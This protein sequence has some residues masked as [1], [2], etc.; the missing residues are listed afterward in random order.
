MKIIYGLTQ[1]KRKLPANAATMGVFDGVHLG[2]QAIL[3]EVVKRSKVLNL[4]SLCVTFWPS[5]KN[6]KLLYSLKHRLYLIEKIGF[7]I[8]VVINFTR[9][10][11]NLSPESFVRGI[12]V[13]KLNTSEII[14]GHGFKFAKHQ[15]G[16]TKLL[17]YLAKK[18]FFRV[19]EID[20]LRKNKT[21]IS[22]THI[23]NLI[24]SG[25]LKEAEYILGRPVVVYG[26]IMKGL[27]LARALGFPTANI[28]P[29]H[30]V[31]PPKGIYIVR[32]FLNNKTYPGVCYIGTRPSIK[33]DNI[34]VEVHIFNFHKDIYGQD[35]YIEFDKL[36]RKEKK[37]KSFSELKLQVEKDLTAAKSFFGIN[38]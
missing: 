33:L 30:E 15:K 34:V 22:S 1:I 21:Y 8:C 5:P 24:M 4:K 31:L 16:N 36:I 26:T 12:L 17:S 27:S 19:R 23:R 10:F 14:I 37:F 20:L 3:K 6:S 28:N 11:S 29:H 7:D 18:Y 32:C 35:L 25:R 9:K 13:G 2:H 38:N